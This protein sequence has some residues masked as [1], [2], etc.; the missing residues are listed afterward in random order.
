MARKNVL[1]GLMEGAT[2]K[3]TD[4]ADSAESRP[5]TRVD[6]ARPR[7]K[8]G[9]I[10]A[11][12]QSIAELKRRSVIEVAPDLIDN[13]GLFDRFD[14][15]EDLPALMRSIE[16]YGQ[17]VPVLLR[18]HPQHDGRYEVVYGRRRVSALIRLKQPVKALVRDLDDRDLVL[19]QGQENAARKDLSFI[20]RANFARQMRDLGYERKV[21]CDA[22]HV[23]KTA[24]SRMLSI[25]DRLP[26]A[27][28]DVIGAA[29]S[30]GRDRWLKLAEMAEKA[31]WAPH[32]LAHGDTSDARFEAVFKALKDHRPAP[33]DP[34]RPAARPV[35]I[36]GPNGE[37]IADVTRKGRKTILSFERKTAQG[38]DEWLAENLSEIH[39][40]WKNRR[41]E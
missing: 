23:D 4:A 28:I 20:E 14:E 25:A 3:G 12:S 5:E 24:I 9:A 16:T 33:A 19:A 39:R 29:P 11:V 26:E 34:P 22:L 27:L 7:Y 17:Q 15:D 21:I 8:T 2:G 32:A 13:A 35:P 10:G 30:V 6:T 37:K 41:A 18:P 1:K 40:D 36:H 31:D 38:F